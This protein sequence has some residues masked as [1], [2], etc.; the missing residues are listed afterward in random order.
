[1]VGTLYDGLTKKWSYP[2]F[3]CTTILCV[4]AFHSVAITAFYYCK[5]VHFNFKKQKKSC[6]APVFRVFFL[7]TSTVPKCFWGNST[8][9]NL[10][11]EITLLVIAT[12]LNFKCFKFERKLLSFSCIWTYYYIFFK[13]IIL[14]I[15]KYVFPMHFT[16]AILFCF[17]LGQCEYNEISFWLC[18]GICDF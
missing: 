2:L 13:K 17:L 15:N 14:C 5:V 9:G 1:M 7:K 16:N 18:M 4:T 12:N 11:G 3:H 6:F 8:I 10:F